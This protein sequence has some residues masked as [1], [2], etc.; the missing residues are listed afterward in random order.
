MTCDRCGQVMAEG[1]TCIDPGDGIAGRYGSEQAGPM[2]DCCRDC[3]T[4]LGDWHHEGCLVARCVSCGAQAVMCEPGVHHVQHG[5]MSLG[6][7]DA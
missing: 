2:L 3:G 7:I 6:E 1:V 5:W 4:P